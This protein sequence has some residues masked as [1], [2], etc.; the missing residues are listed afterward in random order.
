MRAE[1]K[2]ASELTAVI[3]SAV[4]CYAW[5]PAALKR[6]D[7]S[8][9]VILFGKIDSLWAG[10]VTISKWQCVMDAW[11]FPITWQMQTCTAGA[12]AAAAAAAAAT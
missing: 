12:A 5:R 8:A 3:S 6:V 10:F 1:A 11:W 9:Q 4:M 7:G 2:S